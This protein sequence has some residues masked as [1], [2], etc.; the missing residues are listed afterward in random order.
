MEAFE[1]PFADVARLD[2][3]AEHAWPPLR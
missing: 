1:D 2:A 3:R